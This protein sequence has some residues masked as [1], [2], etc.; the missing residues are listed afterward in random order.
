MENN[1]TI[2]VIVPVYKVEQY[3]DQCVESIVG[4]TYRDLEIIL[5]DDGSPDGCPALCDAWAARDSR[6]RVVHQ[7]NSGVAVARNVGLRYA[8]GKYILFV[9]G[10]DALSPETILR[11]YKGIQQ[12]K[13]QLSVSGVL[14]VDEEGEKDFSGNIRDVGEKRPTWESVF[15]TRGVSVWGILYPAEEVKN[16]YFPEGISNLEDMYWN[17]L[18]SMYINEIIYVPEAQYIY[19]NRTDSLTSRCID[20]AWQGGSALRIAARLIQQA[21]KM[22]LNDVQLEILIKRR[23]TLINAGFSELHIAKASLTDEMKS[24]LYAS[25]IRPASIWRSRLDW[26]KKLAEIMIALCPFIESTQVYGTILS[27]RGK[28]K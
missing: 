4:Q 5:V 15:R 13:G 28:K 11:L 18:V 20:A 22:S 19:R 21:K 9:D 12:E 23:R 10:D 16:I 1:E 8:R 2:S 25:K 24:D 14:C 17:S 6:I 3:L 27:F 26:K 7:K